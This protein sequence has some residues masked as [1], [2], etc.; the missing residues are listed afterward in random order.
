[1]KIIKQKNTFVTL[2]CV[3]FCLSFCPQSLSTWLGSF[4]FP[5]EIQTFG[6]N[7]IG[8]LSIGM[9]RFDRENFL[10]KVRYS[11]KIVLNYFISVFF[12]SLIVTRNSYCWQ[13]NSNI[14]SRNIVNVPSRWWWQSLHPVCPSHPSVSRECWYNSV[15]VQCIGNT[16][17]PYQLACAACSLCNKL[18]PRL[19]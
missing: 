16:T 17:L 8:D 14:S 10:L 5:L 1:M 19:W 3:I 4:V 18:C 2:N 7:G 6:L 9:I 11:A 15:A 12:L 13:V